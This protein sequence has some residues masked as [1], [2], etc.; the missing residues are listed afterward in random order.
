MTLNLK[1]ISKLKN[2]I[3]DKIKEIYLDFNVNK[4]NL[5][6][7]LIEFKKILEYEIWVQDKG[8]WKMTNLFKE[9]YNF[10]RGVHLASFKI[11]PFTPPSFGATQVSL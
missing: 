1:F 9:F 11:I 10:Y 5:V 3:I 2:E 7:W 6:D 8:R 4:F